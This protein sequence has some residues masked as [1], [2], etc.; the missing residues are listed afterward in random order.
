M[1]T[2][3]TFSL[4]SPSFLYPSFSYIFFQLLSLSL[5]FLFL[6]HPLNTT[7]ILLTLTLFPTLILHSFI[8]PPL[9]SF[10]TH[11]HTLSLSFLSLSTPPIFFQYYFSPF[12]YYLSTTSFFCPFRFPITLTS[13]FP[14]FLTFM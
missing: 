10:N 7:S 8:T 4:F 9:S 13:F 1:G 6:Y 14:I 5:S 11:T 2:H 12:L 3:Y